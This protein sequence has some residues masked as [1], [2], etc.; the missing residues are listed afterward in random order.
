[1]ILVSF[2]WKIMHILLFF[3]I[4][5]QSHKKYLHLNK[6]FVKMTK[7]INLFITY[8][9][10]HIL[11]F[12][13]VCIIFLYFIH[14]S[15]GTESEISFSLLNGGRGGTNRCNGLD[16][17]TASTRILMS[18]GSKAVKIAAISGKPRV[19]RYLSRECEFAFIFT[20]KIQHT[21]F[22]IHTVPWFHLPFLHLKVPNFWN[23]QPKTLINPF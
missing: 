20:H 17:S 23:F 14:T 5:A 16:T 15:T 6:W 3:T 18:P 10:T 4:F 21:I 19:Q 12:L 9:L 1:M 8:R 13:W 11:S 2:L 22:T 7:D